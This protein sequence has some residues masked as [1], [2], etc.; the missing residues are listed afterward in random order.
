MNIGKIDEEL[1]FGQNKNKQ[2]EKKGTYSRLTTIGIS[3]IKLFAPKLR[4][5]E[6]ERIRKNKKRIKKY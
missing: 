3:S 1:D 6:Q 5:E 2:D 4:R